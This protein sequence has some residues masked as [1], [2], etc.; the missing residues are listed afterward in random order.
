M[1]SSRRSFL[2]TSLGLPAAAAIFR[3]KAWALFMPTDDSNPKHFS[4]PD[5]IRYDSHSFTINGVD[6]FLYSL[7]CPYP[8][9]P[10]ELWGDRFRKARQAGFNAVDAYVFW[11]YHERQEGHF[12]FTELEEFLKL[13]KESG[14]Y[15]MLR[16]GPY[17][18]A[19]FERGGF[20]YWIIAR[21]FPVRS[22]HHE[23][24]KISKYWYDHVLPI[25]RKNQ[26]TQGGPV[27]M[28]Q[29]ENELD[30]TNFSEIEQREYIR[31]LARTA[32]DA[33]I[34][35]PLTTNV[36]SV[37]RD[38]TDP[39]M[40]R[41][42][43]TC[44]FYPRWSFLVDRELQILPPGAT[45]EDKVSQSDRAV[46][47]S[48]RRQRKEQPDRLLAIAELGTGY[49][50][51]VGGKL[52]EDEE[53]VEAA[54]TNAFTKTVIE[55]GATYFNYY[56]G[57]GGTN[58][59]W[60][61]KGVTTTY[62]FAAP[63]REWGG[64]WDKYY[65]LRG[66]GA[67]LGMF[68]KML[69]RSQVL[70]NAC[71]STSA[72]MTVSERTSG[73]SGFVF[74]RTNTESQ[75]HFKLKFR[76]PAGSGNFSVPREGDLLMGPRAMKILPVQI[77][78]VGGR[79]L[80]STAELLA[81]G[82]SHDRSFLVIYDEPGSLVELALGAKEGPHVIGETLYQSWDADNRSVVVGLRIAERES[83]LLL[84]NHLQIVA[85]PRHIALRTW[86]EEFPGSSVPG[87]SGSESIA[88]P[89]IT[90][91]YLL[92][93][94]G[95]EKRKIWV[96]L[97]F[98]PGDHSLT[99]LLPSQPATCR[100]D[101]VSKEVGYD[102]Q[103]RSASVQIVTPALPAKAVE[104]KAVQ[105]SVE[106]FD[107]KLGNWITSPARVLE[108]IGPIPYG[109]VKYKAHLKFNNESKMYISTFTDDGKKVFLNGKYVPEASNPDKFMEFSPSPYLT[110]GDN[111]VE[112]SYELF[113]STEFGDE[114][115]MSELKGVS[116]VRLS[117]DPETS[118]KVES[119]QI[120]T[121]PASMRGR[122]VDPDFSFGAWNTATL[123]A[124]SPTQ[125]LAPAFTWCRAEFALTKVG[126][127]SVPWKLIFEA[128]RDALIYLNGR[129]V[130]R[131]VTVG[132][133][134]EF[135]L[136]EPYLRM[137]TQPNLLTVLLAYTE[138][139]AVIKTLRIEPYVDYSARRT[140]IQ[141][142]W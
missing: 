57:F 110:P 46:L 101:G 53:G 129:F 15:V 63:I 40:V 105:T 103:W 10:R 90:D 20:P 65:E 51:K 36:A 102:R 107:T 99:V 124:A 79:L 59:D 42:M 3:N 118:T 96:D 112:I 133:Q 25:I 26:I 52:S 89:F 106:H 132:P 4:K 41:L 125:D 72:D 56:L 35:V 33:G 140:H 136:P 88:I 70:E 48:I 58:F 115:Q 50:S 122:E 83:F 130:G 69:T 7:E 32:W 13:A 71:H 76:D 138:T 18:D 116:S 98:L 11:N 135:Y 126:G 93:A 94:T 17:V 81:Q 67:F 80:Y 131:S 113:G 109:Y 64:L 43:D 30:F 142:E 28:M 5:I 77:P 8:R 66:I 74:V 104:I 73:E 19:E 39:D 95:S 14:F 75:H 86:V 128:D 78:V 37:V 100:I 123:G 127:W 85:L 1:K 54:Q 114:V 108:D 137:D 45:L 92:V 29:I 62:D 22:M 68:G 21:R 82:M 6:T 120:Q 31:F 16:P 47:A 97:D 38:R 44:D 60:A 12:D 121:F 49:Y 24:L 23:S 9:C 2:Y 34:E 55:Q 111:T 84:N 91:A 27:V 87:A 61:A 117:G 141:F 119:W 139:P 134:M